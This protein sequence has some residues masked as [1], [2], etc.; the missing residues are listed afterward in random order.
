MSPKKTP[1]KRYIFNETTKKNLNALIDALNDKKLKEDYSIKYLKNHETGDY[2][3]IQ[4]LGEDFENT[5][6][7]QQLYTITTT[8]EDRGIGAALKQICDEEFDYSKIKNKKLKRKI[9]DLK[10]NSEHTRHALV[11]ILHTLASIAEIIHL[12]G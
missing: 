10:D 9:K 2:E 8:F 11:E 4:Q 5:R 6:I 12:F 1:K 7:F 3:I